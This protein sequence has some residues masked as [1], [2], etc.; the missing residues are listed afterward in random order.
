MNELLY[1]LLMNCVLKAKIIYL[2]DEGEFNI[3]R[4]QGV[5]VPYLDICSMT[6]PKNGILYGSQHI[7]MAS[8]AMVFEL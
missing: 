8:V 5:G 3:K 7:I 1:S 4:I 2:K 6:Q